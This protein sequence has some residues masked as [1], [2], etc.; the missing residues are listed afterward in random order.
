MPKR[1]RQ[2]GREHAERHELAVRE[3]EHVHH[4]PDQRQPDRDQRV[5]GT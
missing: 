4:P 3:V 5:N 1:K 2:E